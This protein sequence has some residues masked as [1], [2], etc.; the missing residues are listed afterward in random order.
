MTAIG[1]WDRDKPTT[2]YYPRPLP[3]QI[4]EQSLGNVAELSR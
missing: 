1:W 3:T 2:L 4:G